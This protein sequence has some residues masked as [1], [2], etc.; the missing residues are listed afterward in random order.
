MTR[1]MSRRGFIAAGAAALAA[2]SLARAQARAWRFGHQLPTDH[3]IHFGALKVA[4]EVER[5]TSG[6]LRVQVFPA[7]QLGTGQEMDQQ[8]S[9]GALEFAL[10]GPG[11]LGAVSYTH[12]TL[13][14][15]R[16]V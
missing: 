3:P 11:S 15:N 13:P 2:P 14:T 12:L 5:R 4:E 6:R 16:E 7:G 1:R 10:D 9:D 8:V